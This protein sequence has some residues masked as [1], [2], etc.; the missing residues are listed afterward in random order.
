[1]FSSFKCLNA[2]HSKMLLPP[3]EHESLNHRGCVCV[4]VRSVLHKKCHFFSVTTR[5]LLVCVLMCDPFNSLPSSPA[6]Q[7]GSTNTVH[8]TFIFSLVFHARICVLRTVMWHFLWRKNENGKEQSHERQSIPYQERIQLMCVV[9]C[10]CAA[11]CSY[12]FI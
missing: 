4:Y 10:L 8:S 12:V 1:M 5:T 3:N 11:V 7:F 9:K 2:S 6:P